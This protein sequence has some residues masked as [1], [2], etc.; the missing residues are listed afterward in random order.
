MKNLVVLII[1]FVFIGCK[2]ESQ[3]KIGGLRLSA[4]TVNGKILERYEYNSN[5]LLV[6][7]KYFTFCESNPTDEY[8]YIY[9]NEKLDT[10]KSVIRSLYSSTAVICDPASGMPANTLFGYDNDGR[11]NKIFN[12]HSTI[13]LIY[14]EA[15]RVEKRVINDGSADRFIY[16]YKYD[17]KGNLVEEIN[18]Q[19]N[20]TQYA[21][22][23]KINPYYLI[24]AHPDIITAF[25]ASPNNVIKIISQN[26]SKEIKYQYNSAG[27]PIRMSDPNGLTYEYVYE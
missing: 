15:G 19:G 24:K 20:K 27:L 23:N 2:K 12:T 17:S 26:G 25:I 21:F 14:N 8:S 6:K 5:N 13:S 16:N 18:S 11:I 3:D 9:K 1:L 22:D 10:L 4:V 7:A